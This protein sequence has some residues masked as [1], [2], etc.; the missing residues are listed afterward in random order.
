MNTIFPAPRERDESILAAWCTILLKQWVKYAAC[1]YKAACHPERNAMRSAAMNEME[2][3]DLLL[4]AGATIK[5]ISPCVRFALLLEAT[6]CHRR[7]AGRITPQSEQGL[8][9][10]AKVNW[11]S[12]VVP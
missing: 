11:F 7:L 3:R 1:H 10:A 8:S 9:R 5:E 2:S 6:P 12:R 4:Q